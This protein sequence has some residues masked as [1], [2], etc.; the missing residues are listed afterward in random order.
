MPNDPSDVA[1]DHDHSCCPNGTSCVKCHRG[2]AHNACN[3]VTG[4]A[5]EDIDR[6]HR[7]TDN[8]AAVKE[9]VRPELPLTLF[10]MGAV[11]EDAEDAEDVG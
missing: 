11:A 6:L 3:L 9:R 5:D 7:I 8:L 10:E 1:I 2:L 4:L